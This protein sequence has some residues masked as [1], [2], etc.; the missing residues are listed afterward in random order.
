MKHLTRIVAMLALAASFGASAQDKRAQ[1]IGVAAPLTQASRAV[2]L[3]QDTKWVNVKKGETIKFVVKN[4]GKIKHEMVLG[5][6]KE[7]KEH[8]EMMKK[9]PEMEHADANQVT[10]DPGKTGELVWQFTK[11]G[12]FDFACLQPGH[13]EAGMK[14]KVAVK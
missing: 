3:T 4:S 9:M 2:V 5:S 7:L 13:F 10:L 8:G 11:A 14:G 12:K 1:D 6:M